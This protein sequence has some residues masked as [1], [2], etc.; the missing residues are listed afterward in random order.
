MT[1][2]LA[3]TLHFERV[4]GPAAA[5]AALRVVRSL[6]FFLLADACDACVQLAHFITKVPRIFNTTVYKCIDKT[7]RHK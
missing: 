7:M 5:P 3:L 2:Q 4:G 6:F 1:L